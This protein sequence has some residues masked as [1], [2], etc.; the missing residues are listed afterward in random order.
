MKV[1][2]NKEISV[3]TENYMSRLPKD[4]KTELDFI[5]A[6]KNAMLEALSYPEKYIE[7]RPK[8]TSTYQTLGK[9]N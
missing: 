6:I 3:W 8:T 2:N 9:K 1:I 7:E 5:M 4:W